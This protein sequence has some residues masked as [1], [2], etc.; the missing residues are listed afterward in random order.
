[1][2]FHLLPESPAIDRGTTVDAPSA[3]LDG[4]ARPCGGGVDM[5]AFEYGSCGSGSTQFRRGDPNGDGE[6]D[7]SD[8]VAIIWYLFIGGDAPDC[9]RSVDVDD[10][11]EMEIS[12]DVIYLLGYL[13]I[14]GKSPPE[15]FRDCGIDTSSDELTCES[16]PPCL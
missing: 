6:V 3:D 1:M 5:G 12:T 11:G 4:N 10:N 7:I 2:D 15:P 16:Y 13:F 8:A 14:E 9:L